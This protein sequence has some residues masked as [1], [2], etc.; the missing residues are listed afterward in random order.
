ME[1]HEARGRGG[2]LAG[3]A[4]VEDDADHGC[5]REA[6][7]ACGRTDQQGHPGHCLVGVGQLTLASH[8]ACLQSAPGHIAEQSGQHGAGDEYADVPRNQQ[9]RQDDRL[10]EG[11]QL[12]EELC[13]CRCACHAVDRTRQRPWA[14]GRLPTDAAFA[15]T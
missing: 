1:D 4:A 5:C 14:V 6:A 15:V 12:A 8:E 9:A 10:H 13:Q 3:R 7:Q 2:D 11:H